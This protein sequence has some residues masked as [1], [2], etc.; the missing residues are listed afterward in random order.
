MISEKVNAQEALRINED[1]LDIEAVEENLPVVLD[2]VTEKLDKTD[3]SAGIK[4]Q[5]AVAVEEIFINIASYAYNP[6][7]GRA[8]IR[9]AVSEDPLTVTITFIDHGKPY[10]PLARED[11][12]VTLSAEERPVG[13][14]GIFM[15]KQAMDDVSY[16]YKDGSNI[17]RLKK[18]L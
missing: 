10:D 17:L 12:D 2:F 4:M 7:Q 6:D 5:I 16:E 11:P 15:V 18:T 8:V 9:T 13:G 14:L 3:C 1:E